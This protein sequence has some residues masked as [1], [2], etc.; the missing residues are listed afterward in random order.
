MLV[1]VV[2]LLVVLVTHVL[3]HVVDLIYGLRFIYLLRLLFVMPL[4]TFG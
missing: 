2:V 4:S 1:V 3:Q